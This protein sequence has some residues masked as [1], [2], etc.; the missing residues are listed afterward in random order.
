MDLVHQPGTDLFLIELNDLNGICR[1]VVMH[2]AAHVFQLALYWN[3]IFRLVDSVRRLCTVSFQQ[4]QLPEFA[5]VA[6]AN[7]RSTDCGVDAAFTNLR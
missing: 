1:R 6:P 4:H 7:F 2:R 5:K 3:N